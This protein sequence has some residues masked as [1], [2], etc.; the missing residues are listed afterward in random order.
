MNSLAKIHGQI[1]KDLL[2]TVLDDAKMIKNYLTKLTYDE[3]D[4]RIIPAI[5]TVDHADENTKKI[6]NV[7]HIPL[8]VRESQQIIERLGKEIR[9][10]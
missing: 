1:S 2:P 4:E 9:N 6:F 7:S 10:A 3:K 8:P 5:F